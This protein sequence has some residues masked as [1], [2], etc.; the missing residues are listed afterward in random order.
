MHL[1][2][3]P[4]LALTALL[5]GAVLGCGS[6]DA[7]SPPPPPPPP[8]ANRFATLPQLLGPWRPRPLLL[9]PAFRARA[10]ATCRLDMGM[11]EGAV[12]AVIDARGEGVLTLRYAGQA[13]GS[14]DAL[15][16]GPGGTVAGAGGGWTAAW[17]VEEPVDDGELGP[18]EVGQVGGATLD[19]HGWSV[20]GQ[21]GAAIRSVVV[22]PVGRPSFLATLEN[23]WYAG[24]WP[25][26]AGPNQDE[27]QPAVVVRGF[28]ANG[29]ELDSSGR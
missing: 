16:I 25:T 6:A 4:T 18:V 11:P 10:D 3:Q 29:V 28:A 7:E 21:A 23:G 15:E 12:L 1:R 19:V 20:H 22:E 2:L 27:P 24:W 13:S 26:G 5:V 8:P 17:N 9:D 14:C